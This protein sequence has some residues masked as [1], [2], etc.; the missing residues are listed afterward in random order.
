MMKHNRKIV[1]DGDGYGV[2]QLSRT[3]GTWDFLND[4][5][6]PSEQAAR[7]W[8]NGKS[9]GKVERA[10]RLYQ[11]REVDYFTDLVYNPFP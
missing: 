6:F 4:E 8:L 10:A 9:L 11:A 1:R 2:M 3:Y 5:P 7:A